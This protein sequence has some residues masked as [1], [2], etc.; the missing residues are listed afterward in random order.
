MAT[1]WYRKETWSAADKADFET[2]LKR[3]RGTYNKSQYL[4]IQAH[5]LQHA[6]PPLYS[7][8]LELLDRVFNEFRDD[9][10]IASAYL[11]KAQ[12]ILATGD[13]SAAIPY[14]REGLKFELEHPKCRTSAWLEF[15]WQIATERRDDL[16]DEA[17]TILQQQ[18]C[19]L[20]LP[21]DVYRIN[22]VR[23]IIAT[24]KGQH[25]VA[26]SC[27]EAAKQA[28]EAKT[29]GLSYHKN[30]GVVSKHDTWAETA[31]NEILKT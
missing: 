5:H 23:A 10:Q 18:T 17:L 22:L 20:F 16:Y 28:S 12:C 27:A 4:R 1:D 3:S 24:H 7:A 6:T 21:V 13:F 19:S 15:P 2:R 25:D 11:Q 14:Y 8:A 26:R 29:S 9:S 30:L 31:M